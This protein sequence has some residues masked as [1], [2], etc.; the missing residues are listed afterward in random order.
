MPLNDN[1]VSEAGFGATDLANYDSSFVCLNGEVEIKSGS[2]TSLTNL[3]LDYGDVVTC[4]FTNKRKP[5]LNVKKVFNPTTDGGKVD[6]T[7]NGVQDTN[8]DAGFGHNGET[9][10]AE[11]PLNDN[12]VSEAGPATPIS[13]TTTAPT[14]A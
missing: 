5:K 6:F 2:G 10:F 13:R 12:A 3:D 14:C 1:A 11:R 7:V 8:G 4:T 9:G